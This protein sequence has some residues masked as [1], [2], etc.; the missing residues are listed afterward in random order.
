MKF[1]VG[2]MVM[3]LAVS[4]SAAT[5]KGTNILNASYWLTEEGDL[6]GVKIVGH[7]ATGR[8]VSCN[9]GL[10]AQYI[11][12]VDGIDCS[13]EKCLLL[14]F[15]KGEMRLDGRVPVHARIYIEKYDYRSQVT[16]GYVENERVY[17]SSLTKL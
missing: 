9:T 14:F 8:S 13:Q 1:F 4:V 10:A 6:S 16:I 7:T 5:S 2:V 3:L 12:M 15:K 11:G 17:F